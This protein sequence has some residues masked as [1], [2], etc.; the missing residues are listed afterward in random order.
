MK[1]MQN[2]CAH[3]LDKTG[4]QRHGH[5]DAWANLCEVELGGKDLGHGVEVCRLK[6]EAV[7]VLKRY[8]GDA[9][10]I[11]AH[12]ASWLRDHDPERFALSLD[13]P[14]MDVHL[15]DDD[16]ADIDFGISFEEAVEIVPA[17]DGPISWQGRRWR[18]APV[19]VD[20]AETLDNMD[21]AA[22]VAG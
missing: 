7:I 6:Y 15:N 18:V 22:G 4:L 12:V 2:L 16:T 13:D 8:P 20:V 3:L 5:F 17:E 11:T 21:G 19:P 9:F 1:K 14:D 10:E